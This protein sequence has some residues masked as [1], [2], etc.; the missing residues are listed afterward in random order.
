MFF[1][2]KIKF[3]RKRVE[4]KLMLI[5]LVHVSITLCASGLFDV[6]VSENGFPDE[7]SEF[8]HSRL[9]LECCKLQLS[10][11]LA[12]IINFPNSMELET[13]IRRRSRADF[14]SD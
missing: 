1:E 13:S 4:L 14:T 7:L 9:S 11:F 8:M 5:C 2:R 12:A 10:A 3:T 6:H